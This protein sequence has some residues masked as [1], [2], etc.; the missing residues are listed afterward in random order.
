MRY[1]LLVLLLGTSV[2]W[3]QEPRLEQRESQWELNYGSQIERRIE[4]RFPRFR[5]LAPGDYLP[6]IVKDYRFSSKQ[7]PYAVVGDFNGDGRSDLVVDGHDDVHFLR[8]LFLSPKYQGQVAESLVWTDPKTQVY[9][10]GEEHQRGHSVFLEFVGPGMLDVPIGKQRPVR[11]KFDAFQ[12]VFFGK[13]SIV[14]YW[15]KGKFE[16]YYTS[17]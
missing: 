8:L 5:H 17:D 12:L 4:K 7:A 11:L 3:A 13:A 6:A 2:G 16:E 14:H 10:V 15:S 1:S 9:P